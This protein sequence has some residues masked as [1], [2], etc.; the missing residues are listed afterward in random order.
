MGKLG[1]EA[2][3][4]SALI[5]GRLLNPGIKN[6]EANDPNDSLKSVRRTCHKWRS[7][8]VKGQIERKN[9]FQVDHLR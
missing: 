8:V 1:Q 6:F 4:M 9:K 3:E 7:K 2:L 5:F